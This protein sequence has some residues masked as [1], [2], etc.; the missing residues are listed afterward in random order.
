M[1]KSNREEVDLSAWEVREVI[2][3]CAPR[4]SISRKKSY[5]SR[6]CRSPAG[7]R[8]GNLLGTTR[9]C[10]PGPL[11]GEPGFLRAMISGGVW[12]SFPEQKGQSGS[13][14]GSGSAVS[15]IFKSSGRR[16]LS[17]ATMTQFF[18]ALFC[19]STDILVPPVAD[20]SRGPMPRRPAPGQVLAELIV[21]QGIVAA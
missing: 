18:V 3:S 13:W 6:R 8:A 15:T 11:G 17:P 19:L 7:R 1:S 14:A 21:S 5:F 12:D 4:P 16:D 10:Q 2:T 20:S 9:S